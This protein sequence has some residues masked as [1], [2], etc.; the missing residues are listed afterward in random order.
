M[1]DNI[2]EFL[3][4]EIILLGLLSIFFS[5]TFFRL[6]KKWLKKILVFAIIVMFIDII[7]MILIFWEI[8]KIENSNSKYYHYAIK[9]EYDTISPKI[10]TRVFISPYLGQERKSLYEFNFITKLYSK[11]LIN[12][13]ERFLNSKELKN[14]ISDKLPIFYEDSSGAGIFASLKKDTLYLIANVSYTYDVDSLNSAATEAESF[15][16]FNSNSY[17]VKI[18]F[19]IESFDSSMIGKNVLRVRSKDL[20]FTQDIKQVNNPFVKTWH[21]LIKYP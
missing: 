20:L 5:I 3:S 18:S 21:R 13:K 4:D 11:F 1:L 10:Y 19:D 8:N 9:I 2:T 6:K 7:N 15:L 16:N 12:S 14:I 17:V